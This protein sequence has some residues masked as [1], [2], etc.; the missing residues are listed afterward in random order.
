ML[1]PL[2]AGQLHLGIALVSAVNDDAVNLLFES[3]LDM[4]G[5]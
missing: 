2:Q 1:L 4:V 5:Y 3:S